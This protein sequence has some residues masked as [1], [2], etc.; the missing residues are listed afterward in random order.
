MR[1]TAEDTIVDIAGRYTREEKTMKFTTLI[2]T[3]RN[4]GSKVKPSELVGLINKLFHAF[5]AYTIE[6]K[7]KGVWMDEGK[8]YHDE[9]L[10]IVIACEEDKLELA[11]RLVI[12]I[13][14]QLGQLA[15]YFEIDRTSEVR[16][17]RIEK[18]SP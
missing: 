5:G 18:R 17:L 10:K 16:N 2:P 8:T 14:R 13:G 15:M 9:C 11:Q 6:G 4:D 7:V 3:R 1:D 12:E